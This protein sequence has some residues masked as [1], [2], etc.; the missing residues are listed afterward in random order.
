[1]YSWN[2][3]ISIVT[4]FMFHKIVSYLWFVHTLASWL[5]SFCRLASIVLGWQKRHTGQSIVLAS[6]ALTCARGRVNH[7]WLETSWL[8]LVG[9]FRSQRCIINQVFVFFNYGGL[10]FLSI[11]QCYGS[12]V[13]FDE[14]L[15]HSQYFGKKLLKC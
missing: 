11:Y 6:R 4:T 12:V 1:M 15:P 14:L 7:L 2:T 9:I 10:K 8:N 3:T 13:I 5:Q